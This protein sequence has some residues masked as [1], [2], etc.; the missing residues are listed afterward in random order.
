MTG[1]V[2]DISPGL[3]KKINQYLKNVEDKEKIFET[4]FEYYKTKIK[5]E[6][7]EMQVDIEDF[8]K[9]YNM[10]SKEFYKKFENGE[11]EDNNDFIL[12]SGIIE[13]QK[14]STEKLNQ[15]S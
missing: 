5:R 14:K 12:W 1:L 8:E 7:S 13:M 11:L 9:K 2:L 4:F 15:L 10:S 6:I 3:A